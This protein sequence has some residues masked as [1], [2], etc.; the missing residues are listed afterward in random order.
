MTELFVK[1]GPL[2]Y[3]LLLSSIIAFAFALERSIFFFLAGRRP[4][5]AITI[6]DLL[7]KGETER[8][9][10]L[11][12][13]TPGPVAAILEAGLRHAGAPKEQ[14]EEVINLKG[15]AELKR[16]DQ[17]L[18]VIELVGRIAPLLGLLGT[19]LGLV[20]AFREIS[21]STGG[22][23]PSMLAG[24][25]WEALITTVAG[26]TIAIPAM[27]AHHFLE[28]RVQSFAWQMKH[29]GTEALKHL[30]GGR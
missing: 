27:V 16:L 3:P 10:E 1:G 11:A 13:A 30:G 19:V 29:Y 28:H 5:S 12:A 2:M 4:G 22:I 24:G 6:H 15:S 17:N 23:D 18:H 26:M 8:A 20:D 21:S 7:E 9:L 25:I 14:L